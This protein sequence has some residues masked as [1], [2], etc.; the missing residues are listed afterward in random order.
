MK[1]V[2]L[3]ALALIFV[4]C[5]DDKAE[6]VKEEKLVS[7]KEI[8]KEVIKEPKKEIIK[9]IAVKAKVVEPVKAIEPIEQ[10]EDIV[11]KTVDTIPAAKSQETVYKAC[12][13]CHGAKGEKAALGKS[14]II[15]DM[16]ASE[17][18]TALLGYKNKTYGG[19]MKGLMEGQIKVNKLS[20]EDIKALSEYINKL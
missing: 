10:K 3:I 9:P 5:S 6:Q 16:S 14:K 4:G 18:E 7:T 2:I 15:K 13:S 1:K 19:A 17:I 20:D 12:S 8:K 11:I